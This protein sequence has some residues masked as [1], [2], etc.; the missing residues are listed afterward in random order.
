MA[1]LEHSLWGRG[2]S[3]KMQLI[4]QREEGQPQGPNATQALIDSLIFSQSK[5]VRTSTMILGAFNI[6]AAFV[7][8]SSILYDCYW[9]SKRANG[10]CKAKYAWMGPVEVEEANI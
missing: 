7:T 2:N 3:D 5:S 6:L 8:A 4:Y 10:G 1:D 9:A